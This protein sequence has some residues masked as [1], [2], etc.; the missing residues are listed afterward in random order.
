MDPSITSN[1]KS[2]AI[3]DQDK[4]VIREGIVEAVAVAP[5][6]I[7]SQLA[8]FVST[9]I[10]HDFPQRWPDLVE[11]LK[12]YLNKNDSR[13]C[14]GAL[15]VL[16]RLAKV[17]EYKKKQSRVLFDEAMKTLVT[18]LYDKMSGYLNDGSEEAAMIRKIITK[19]FFVH[20][21]IIMPSDLLKPKVFIKWAEI[22][23][24]LMDKKVAEEA[25]VD[26]EDEEKA[27]LVL[28]LSLI[29]I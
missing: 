22:L 10:E 23:C 16:Y 2:L 29:H 25:Q 15:L 5:V 21:N 3:P 20:T 4:I 24:L 1:D 19:I 26:L 6:R 12:L 17:Y 14:L 27:N 9:I 18:L 11:K 8:V 7:Q 13:Q 28:W